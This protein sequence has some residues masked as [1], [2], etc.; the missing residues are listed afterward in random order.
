MWRNDKISQPRR[1]KSEVLVNHMYITPII[2]IYGA[3]FLAILY[4]LKNRKNEMSTLSINL[5][6]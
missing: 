1:R 2:Y 4:L 3:G 5:Q 6:T